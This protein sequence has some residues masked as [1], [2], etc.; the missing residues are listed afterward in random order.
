M[1]KE[2][3]DYVSYLLRLRLSDQDGQPTW[4]ASLESTRDGQR[5]DFCSVEELVAFLTD[6]FG[7]T[8]CSAV[9]GERE[10]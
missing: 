1:D 10:R 6:R 4:R 5:T 3:E 8:G 2:R 7:R 9:E